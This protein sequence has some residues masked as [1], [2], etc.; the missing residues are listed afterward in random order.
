MKESEYSKDFDWISPPSKGERL[1]FTFDPLV[2]SIQR[3]CADIPRSLPRRHGP[4]VKKLH[5]CGN[6]RSYFCCLM[7]C[8]RFFYPW[9]RKCLLNAFI[10]ALKKKIITVHDCLMEFCASYAYDV[11]YLRNKP[12][13][14][15]VKI[16]YKDILQRW[17]EKIIGQHKTHDIA[18]RGAEQS[19]G[20]AGGRAAVAETRQEHRGSALEYSRRNAAYKIIE[21][22][23][24]ESLLLLRSLRYEIHRLA[25]AHQGWISPRFTGYAAH[26]EGASRRKLRAGL[27]VT[28]QHRYLG[29]VA[30]AI[31]NVAG[32]TPPFGRDHR[33]ERQSYE[34]RVCVVS[35][36]VRAITPGR[37]PEARPDSEHKPGRRPP[38]SEQRWT[39]AAA[40]QRERENG[41]RAGCTEGR[42]RSRQ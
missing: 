20:R 16:S 7:Q 13:P 4:S 39:F 9:S 3:T 8:D 17:N 27:R 37:L 23:K 30:R 21:T 11:R 28:R 40:G 26:G 10:L 18:R 25:F 38:V 33:A 41:P 2:S 42:P 22:R 1:G 36:R 6:I 35:D 31:G 29:A 32:F 34:Y 5:R 15:D 24:E 12:V 19:D 14:C